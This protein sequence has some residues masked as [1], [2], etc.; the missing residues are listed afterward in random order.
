MP[1]L[2]LKISKKLPIATQEFLA[3]ELTRL[4][5]EILH[6]EPTLTAITIEELEQSHWF[7]NGKLQTIGVHLAIIVN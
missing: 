3:A 2:N 4:M 1:Y 6:K 7:I 5:A